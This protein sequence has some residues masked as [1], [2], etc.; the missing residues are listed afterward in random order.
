MSAS[1][2]RET[3]TRAR[4]CSLAP[5][6]GIEAIRAPHRDERSEPSGFIIGGPH[7]SVL[8]LPDFDKEERRDRAIEDVIATDDG[9]PI[10]GT[11][12]ADGAVGRHMEEI[13][14]PF[15]RES[16]APSAT[17]SISDRVKIHFAHFNHTNRTPVNPSEAAKNVLS[18]GHRLARRGVL[19]APREA[20]RAPAEGP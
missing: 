12:T 6:L 16:A 13:P 20:T 8:R 9:S 2:T 18:Q 3:W 15:A 10:D 4:P 17:L 1:S 7:R 11:L 19:T 5:G 14:P